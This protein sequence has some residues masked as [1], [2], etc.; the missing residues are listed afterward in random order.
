MKNDTSLDNT[1]NLRDSST[2]SLWQT[3]RKPVEKKIIQFT[4]DTVYDVLVIGAGITGVTT[5]LMLQNQGKKCIIAEMGTLGYGTTGGTTSHI[6]TIFDTSYSEID[7]DFGS[8]AS[9]IVADSGKEAIAI[10]AE[11]VDKYNIDCDFEYKNAYLFAENEQQTKQL[12]EIIT[13]SQQAGV[14][15]KEVSTVDMPMAFQKAA[16]F[17]NQAQIHPLKY[18]TKLAEA[19]IEADGVIVENTCI[20]KTSYKNNVHVAESDLLNIKAKALVYATH[21]PPGINLLHFRCAPY[22]SYVLGIKLMD[23]HYPEGLIYDMQKPYHYLRTH[24]LDGEKYLILGGEDHKT[25]HGSPEQSFADLEA[26][27]R[28]YYKIESIPFKWS[29][30]YYESADGLP[31]I[32]HLPGA[33]DN[34]FV[35][36]GFSGNGITY[37]TISG[38]IL[39]DLILEIDNKYI[40]LFKPERIKPIAG[41]KEFVKENV[42]AAYHFVAD[43]LSVDDIE[44]FNEIE[45][46]QGK[47]VNYNDK[48]LAL[49]KT[50]DGKIHALNPV[51]THA[52]CIVNWNG[53]EKSWDCPCHG[54][55]F[56]INGNV[57]TGPPSKNLQKY[58]FE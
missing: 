31:Y 25:G 58:D 50:T 5:A 27:A 51:C 46:G 38:K 16:M 17:S 44:S 4:E 57:L 3:E 13:S 1:I 41:F 37:G 55:R 48:K 39:V 52:K 47:V 15:I 53:E 8:S 6:N 43:R 35:A 11:M 56:D 12:S 42:D 29:S 49:Y 36:T 20:K 18:I 10:I 7:N 9:K 54:G 26:Y 32:G 30:Q 33:D 2:K 28:S 19:F 24:I 34:T 21:I 45:P 40:H 23:N 22:R 14:V